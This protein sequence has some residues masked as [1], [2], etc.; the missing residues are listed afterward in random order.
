MQ[1]LPPTSPFPALVLRPQPA[2]YFKPKAER[3]DAL[4]LGYRRTLS[5]G[6]VEAVL[7][8]HD[9]RRLNAS[10]TDPA[11]AVSGAAPL[12]VQQFFRSYFGNAR[13]TGLR[14]GGPTWSLSATLRLQASYT[15]L[16]TQARRYADPAAS[17]SSAAPRGARPITGGASMPCGR[18]APATSS[19]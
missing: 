9:Y 6:S 15:V 16:D 11:A 5:N 4:E 2:L 3:V 12:P 17:A 10:L 14:A 1:P 18:R 8:H 7:F 13:T 19:T